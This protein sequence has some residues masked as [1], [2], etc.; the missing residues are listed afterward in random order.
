MELN[1]FFFF[2]FYCG[3]GCDTCCLMQREGN[4]VDSKSV[5]LAV[6]LGDET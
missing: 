4:C 2:S 1:F 3:G 5:V 6:V